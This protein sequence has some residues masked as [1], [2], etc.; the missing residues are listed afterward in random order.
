[1]RI[2]HAVLRSRPV[3]SRIVRAGVVRAGVVRAGVVRAGVVRVCGALLAAVA[4]VGLTADSADSPEPGAAYYLYWLAAAPTQT[5]PTPKETAT[6]SPTWSSADRK[7][8]SKQVAAYLAERGRDGD[9]AVAVRDVKSGAAFSYGG[10]LRP[11]TASIVKVDILMALLLRHGLSTTERSLAENMIRHSDN[12]STTALWNALGGGDALAKANRRFGLKSTVPGPGGAWGSTTTSA[13]D[14]V[15]LL[16]AL[17]SSKSPLSA[18]RRRYVLG[19]M[20]SVATDQAWGVSAGAADGDDVALKNGW[21]P[22]TVDGGAWTIN[23]IGRISGDDHDY[24]IAVVSR[25]HPSMAAGVATV[26]HVATLVTHA[27]GRAA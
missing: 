18:A 27:L 2:R 24:L 16:N 17:T 26:E 10:G 1:M 23:S 21:L 19:L 8:L 5:Q 22:R 9:L 20:G 13:A 6:P 11:A 25:G 12:A 3:R 4:M 14:Q 7:R 15:R